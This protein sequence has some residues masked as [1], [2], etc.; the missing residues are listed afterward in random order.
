MGAAEGLD[1]A[2]DFRGLRHVQVAATERRRHDQRQ[3]HRRADIQALF[4]PLR[5]AVVAL[6]RHVVHL[7]DRQRRNGQPGPRD[8]LAVGRLVF[9][10]AEPH[11]V[12]CRAEI[13]LHAV[14]SD[15][16]GHVQSGRVAALAQR[17]IASADLKPAALRRGEKRREDGIAA[18]ERGCRGGMA[19]QFAAREDSV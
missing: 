19:K 8:R 10:R 9:G 7:A 4:E 12:P 18:G 11:L 14:Q 3:L 13:G 17:P 16:F 6:Q 15:L 2:V 1:E 5:R